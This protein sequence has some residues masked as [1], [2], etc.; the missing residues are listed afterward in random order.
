MSL[1]N[2]LTTCQLF[3]ILKYGGHPV[4]CPGASICINPAV[5][6]RMQE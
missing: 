2:D 4:G 1:V 6:W 5:Q 3:N